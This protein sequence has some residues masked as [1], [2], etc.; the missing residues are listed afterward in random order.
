MRKGFTLIELLIVIAIIGLLATLAIVS[1]SSAQRK[2][3]DAKRA[4]DVKQLQSAIELYFSQNSNGEYPERTTW[5]GATSLET[6]LSPYLTQMPLDPD[7]DTTYYYVYA[8]ND[9]R[10]EYVVGTNFENAAD[11]ATALAGDDDTTY[12]TSTSGWTGLATQ[13]AVSTSS[14]PASGTM[15]GT[16]AQVTCN[17]T[18]LST[19]YCLSE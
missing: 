3:R 19:A 9:A 13:R 4:S 12:T 1:L 14:T 5:T 18:T 10:N 16:A 11:N 2:A 15:A 7:N 8:V 17:D 6:D